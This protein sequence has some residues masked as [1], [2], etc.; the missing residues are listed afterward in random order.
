MVASEATLWLLLMQA[1]L[2]FFAIAYT[3]TKIFTSA[4][5]TV[6]GGAVFV[7]L[8]KPEKIA[9]RVTNGVITDIHSYPSNKG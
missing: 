3:I 7:M 6:F 8:A 4:L 2:E 5:G 1:A 9:N